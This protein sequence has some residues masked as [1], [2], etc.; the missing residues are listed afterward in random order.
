[1]MLIEETSRYE[2]QTNVEVYNKPVLRQT[3]PNA[4]WMGSFS[5]EPLS[6]TLRGS[7]GSRPVVICE[8]M[9]RSLFPRGGLLQSIDQ[10]ASFSLVTQ[11]D[12]S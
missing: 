2:Q 6:L 9:R 4:S 7:P 8:R 3:Q 5:K 12:E 1:M 11:R 10:E